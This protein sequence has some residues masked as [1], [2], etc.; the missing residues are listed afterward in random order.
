MQQRHMMRRLATL[1]L[2]AG[3]CAAGLCACGAASSQQ[4]EPPVTDP[5]Q[6]V[7]A[8]ELYDRGVQLAAREDY[9]RAEQYFVAAIQRGHDETTIL[10]RLL[11]ACV[12]SS[13]LSAALGYAEP[14]L[15]RHPDAWSLRLL[16]ATIHMGLGEN[17]QAHAALVRVLQDQP[18][19][20]AAHYMFAVFARDQLSDAAAS[21]AS[22]RRYLEL[23]PEGEHVLEA[24][25]AV[26]HGERAAAAPPGP[27]RLPSEAATAA[28]AEEATP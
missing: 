1:T 23:E 17:E 21:E 22:F 5:L 19:S 3:L 26:A 27:V 11:S 8:Q 9:V 2:A 24:R 10:P 7:T 16:V 25:S 4:E 18:E 14:Y 12:R 15:E 28:P 13:R 6:T 20:A